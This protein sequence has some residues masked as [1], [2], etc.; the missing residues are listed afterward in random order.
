MVDARYTLYTVSTNNTKNLPAYDYSDLQ[1]SEP[2]SRNATFTIAI[3][4]LFNQYAN[5]AGLIGEGVPAPL[6]GYATAANYAAYIGK[7][8]T[9]WFGL[10]YRQIY[11]SL[12]FRR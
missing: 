3:S 9:E 1:F 10:P 12:Q 8:A 6:N 2:V 5:I 7:A 4:N 11:F